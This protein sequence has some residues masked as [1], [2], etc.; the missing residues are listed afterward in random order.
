MISPVRTI[1]SVVSRQRHVTEGDVGGDQ[2]D[3][4][5]LGRQHHRDV[6]AAGQVGQPFRVSG[7]RKSGEM[8][9]V[10]LGRCG[11]DGVHLAIQGKARGVFDRPAGDQ[12]S[13]DRRGACRTV[14]LA[15]GAGGDAV[16]RAQVGELF[17]GADCGDL[18]INSGV[19]YCGGDF[20]SDASWISQRDREPD[21]RS[22]GSRMS[23]Y[24]LARN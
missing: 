1:R 12:A 20:R 13:F 17:P 16:I 11:D 14:R 22:H 7:K 9:G 18:G 5:A 8:Q 3:P 21:A 10:L 2:H 4:Q 23:T 15:P 19:E 24:V 6:A